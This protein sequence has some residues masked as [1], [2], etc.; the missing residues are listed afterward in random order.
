MA[1]KSKDELMEAL[2]RVFAD[3]TDDNTLELIT[4]ISDTVD[5]LNRQVTESGEWEQKYNE[6][7][8]QWRE[9]YRDTFFNPSVKDEIKKEEKQEDSEEKPLTFDSLFKTEL[10]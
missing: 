1:V 9:K 2:K 7:D 6:N 5:D 4:D 3:A 10:V 8:K